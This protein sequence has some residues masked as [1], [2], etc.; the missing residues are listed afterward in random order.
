MHEIFSF[1]QTGMHAEL[2]AEGHFRA[3]GIRPHFLNRLKVMGASLPPEIFIER[4][5]QSPISR[6][7]AR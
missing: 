2:G 3:T 4:R 6:G 1:V 5:L 7:S